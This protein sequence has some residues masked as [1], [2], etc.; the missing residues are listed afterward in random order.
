MFEALM[1]FCFIPLGLPLLG[2]L[3]VIGIQRRIDLCD[4]MRRGE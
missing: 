4:A 3:V 1:I 2:M